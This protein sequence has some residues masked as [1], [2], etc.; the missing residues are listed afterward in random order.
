MILVPILATLENRWGHSS[1]QNLHEILWYL[2]EA[3]TSAKS[4]GRYLDEK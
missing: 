3:G 4:G 1:Y 2:Y